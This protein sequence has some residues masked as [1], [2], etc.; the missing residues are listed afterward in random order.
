MFQKIF[1]NQKGFTFLELM[2]VVAVTVIITSV[3][4]VSTKRTVSD[5]VDGSTN[6][7]LSDIRYARGLATSRAAYDFDG[8]GPQPAVYPAGGYGVYFTDNDYQ[9]YIFADK[10]TVKGF[11]P[12]DDKI[13]KSASLQNAILD[14]EDF[15]QQ[16][17]A[18]TKYFT[19]KSENEADTNFSTDSNG[20]YK[21]SVSYNP[22]P[23]RTGYQSIIT[24]GEVAT[25][26]SIFVSLG[27]GSQG[28]SP[29]CSDT[30]QGCDGA[31][32]CCPGKNLTCTNNVCKVYT[33]TPPRTS[34]FPAGTKVLMADSSYKNIEDVQVGDYVTSYD[35]N[36]NREVPAKVLELS[37]P[38]REHMCELAFTDDVLKLTDEHP[39]YTSEGWKSINPEKTIEEN[40]NIPVSQL[41]LGDTVFF[42]GGIYKEVTKINCW[43]EVVQTYNLKAVE[44]H[45]TF[46][47]DNV[48]VHNAA[49][50]SCGGD[51]DPAG[52]ANIG[53]DL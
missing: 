41:T 48:L 2:I 38:V 12:G 47:A 20:K 10:G 17:G 49:S 5:Q 46:F 22:G 19:F 15:N 50:P 40:E 43:Q 33:Y 42:K 44:N 36:I 11:T 52:S 6:Q 24:L 32:L 21:M 9:Y 31:Q 1:H 37:S 34:C 13:I 51:A 8:T 39:V 29:V 3:F 25:D 14:L 18:T 28:Y 30:D 53:A 35:E 16:T 26:G 4:I 7:L 27:L 45:N 23:G